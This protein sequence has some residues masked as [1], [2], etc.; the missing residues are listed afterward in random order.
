MKELN[1]ILPYFM[2]YCWTGDIVRNFYENQIL[3][4]K[5]ILQKIKIESV[6]NG[7]NP[8][9]LLEIDDHQQVKSIEKT[10][11]KNLRVMILKNR[12]AYG[13]NIENIK[14][15]IGEKSI[16]EE[17][18]NLNPTKNYRRFGSLLGYPKCCTEFF[19][20]SCIK[21]LDP[22]WLIALNSRKL[23]FIDN[24]IEM[25][26]I[27]ETNIFLSCLGI[28]IINH[29]PCSFNCELSIKKGVE[30]MNQ[31]IKYGYRKEI[32]TLR[33]ILNFP[34]EWSALHGISEIVNPLFKISTRTDATKNKYTIK[35]RNNNNIENIF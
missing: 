11:Q 8:C 12:L 3:D 34:L 32:Q 7:I 18:R 6:E 33:D 13:Q 4:L 19:Y 35:I 21:V 9:C 5:K 26:A 16:V 22:I 10:I 28:K 15:V 20:E 27:P 31:G 30:F 2:H 24:L 14:I 17:I 1:F 25:Y 23:E 29:I